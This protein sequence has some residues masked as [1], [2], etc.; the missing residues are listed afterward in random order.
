M[1]SLRECFALRNP[2]LGYMAP[3]VSTSASIAAIERK[4]V[5]VISA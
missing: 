4:L 1:R 3:N 2:S 5:G